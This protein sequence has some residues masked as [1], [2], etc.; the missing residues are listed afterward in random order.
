MPENEAPQ[1]GGL[2]QVTGTLTRHRWLII[3]T[4]STVA[5]ATVA[6]LYQIPN[7]YTSQATL[8]VI[9]QQVPARYVTPTTETDIVDAVQTMTQDVL[10]RTRLLELIDQFGLYTKERQ[11]LAPEEVITL[12]RKYIEILPVD[13]T[14]GH[15]DV[16]AFKISFSAEKAVLAQ[17]VTSKL[18]SFFIQANLKTREDQATSTNTFLQEHLEAAKTSLATQEEK[19][20]QFKTQYL[21]EL[22]E[23]QQGNLAIFSGAQMQL[24]NIAGALDRAEQ[25]KVY[26]ESLIEGYRRLMS[27]G[28]QVP[29]VPGQVMARSVSPL[30]SAQDDLTRLQLEKQRLLSSYNAA[31]PDVLTVERNI[32][33]AQ[34]R[35]DDL[36]AGKG[37]EAESEPS[38]KAA[39]AATGATGATGSTTKP[40]DALDDDSAITQLKSQLDANRLEIDNLTKDETKQKALIQE[41]QN[42]LN[43]TPVREEQLS[44]ILSDYSLAKKDY[45][46]L[47]GKEQQSE[48]AMSLEKQQGGQQF[49][50]VEPPSL[51][52]LPSSPKRLPISLGGIGGGLFLGLALAF[53]KDLAR[54]TFH[55]AKEISQKF[56]APLVIALPVVLTSREQRRRGWRKAFEFVGA[57]VLVVMIGAAEFYVFVHP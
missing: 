4:A 43:L 52:A 38:A 44:S 6:V 2:S 54:P 48:L 19:L 34:K 26:L 53:V 20:R 9:P 50:L 24:Q 49:R 7:R 51:P 36:K 17:E 40:P 35:V 21:G 37:A 27:R 10:S 45:E 14:P 12:M 13:P 23:Q 11:R 31:H 1:S 47:L 15:K 18:T 25:Q 57:T 16:N 3:L 5:L 39:V 28:A 56:G 8:L 30:Q 29:G 41:Y 46:D 33:E 42:R 22:P 55:S 32:V